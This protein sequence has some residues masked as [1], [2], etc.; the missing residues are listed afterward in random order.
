[1][2]I[3]FFIDKAQTVQLILGLLIESKRRGHEC[4]VFS[5]CDPSCLSSEMHSQIDI[6]GVSWHVRRDRHSL[7]DCVLSNADM[8]HAMVGI[9]LF[10]NIWRDVYETRNIPTTVYSVEYCWNEI[11]NHRSDYNGNST[12]FSNSEW[13]KNVIE[14]LTGYSNIKFLGSP[15]FEL[16]KRFRVE[17]KD[18]KENRFITFMSP[19]NSFINNYPGF[20]NKTRVFL[21][22]LRGYCDK[23]GYGLVLKTRNKYG[24]KLD[25]V[26]NFD[27][28]ISDNKALSHLCLYANSE[29]VI[30]FSSSTINE[31]SFLEVPSLCVFPDFHANLHKERDNLFRAMSKIN[32]KYYSGDIFDGIHTDMI[33]SGEFHS[34]DQFRDKMSDNMEK[35]DNLI[36]SNKRDWQSFQKTYFP[37]NHENSSGRILDYIEKQCFKKV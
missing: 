21:E 32:E 17:K 13:T 37:G 1:M 5:T 27:S 11:Y 22:C 23:K 4:G 2:N 19:H 29:C 26:V 24:H 3:G 8:Y 31:L 6:S 33:E 18:R 28:V 10:N 30:N 15:W 20:L 14:D 7:K 16:I 9:N 25:K 34:N 35:L 36:L 12:L